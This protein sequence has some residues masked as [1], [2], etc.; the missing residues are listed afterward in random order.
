MKVLWVTFAPIGHAA[1]LFYNTTTQ[2]GGWVDATLSKLLPYIRDN[3]VS[4]EIVALD[5]QDR[6][7]HDEATNVTY[8]TVQLPRYRSKRGGAADVAKWEAVL[9]EIKPDIIQVWGT[10]FTFGA[11]ILDAAG[12]IPVCFYIQG[13]MSSLTA[14][15]FGDV[16]A[17]TLKRMAGATAFF[18][19]RSLRKWQ[20]IDKAQVPFEADMVKRAAGIIG[21]SDWARA[22]YH[23][24]TDKFYTVPLAIL[25]RFQEGG[26]DLNAC[27]KHTLFTVAGGAC[28]Q[29]GVHNAVLAIAQL[30]QKYPDIRLYIPGNVT[31]KKPNFLYDS[32]YIRHLRK[33]I[34]RYSL[35][36]NVVFLGSLKPEQMMQHMQSAHCFVMPSCVENHSST[37]REAMLLGCPS[38]SAAIGSVPEFIAHGIS[39]F[40]YRYD[41]ISSLAYYI[42]KIFSDDAL[43]QALAVSG[44][45]S[46]NE[47]Y[48]Q[49]QIGTLLMKAYQSM[50]TS[51]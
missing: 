3:T 4:L 1:E 31:Y 19:F 51:E 28:P 22:Q 14:H 18:K 15:P 21:D 23:M 34:N 44:Q 16:P 27:E 35:H 13:V 37:L 33:L 2:S 20:K 5:N 46:V 39:G 30:K 47:K 24:Y 38:V 26:W 41:E 29:K 9:K 40:T 48:P 12:E 8:R 50:V 17:S 45:R 10:E 42:D 25:P 49:E 32:I 6:V 7:L 43:A 11:D 36:D